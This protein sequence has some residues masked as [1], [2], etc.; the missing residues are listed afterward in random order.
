MTVSEAILEHAAM[1]L[2]ESAEFM[3][4]SIAPRKGD[5]LLLVGVV[6]GEAENFPAVNIR[7]GNHSSAWINIQEC[8]SRTVAWFRPDPV[9]QRLAEIEIQIKMLER[10]KAKLA[11]KGEG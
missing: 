11:T 9:R 7:F 1:T 5:V 8:S 2:S 4:G 3:P 10:E 6:T